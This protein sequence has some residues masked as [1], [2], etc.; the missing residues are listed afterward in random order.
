MLPLELVNVIDDTAETTR[1]VRTL[2]QGDLPEYTPVLPEYKSI[3]QAPSYD[4]I[5]HDANPSPNSDVQIGNE[6]EHLPNPHS[7]DQRYT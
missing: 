1:S 3:Y 5:S 4:G 2:E 6:D 7:S